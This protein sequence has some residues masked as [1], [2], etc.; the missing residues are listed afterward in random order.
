MHD[1][2]LNMILVSAAT[3]EKK[4]KSS[5]GNIRIPVQAFLQYR[6]LSSIVLIYRFHEIRNVISEISNQNMDKMSFS[7]IKPELEMKQ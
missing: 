2:Q 4:T 5:N 3:K 7:G 1:F 6:R